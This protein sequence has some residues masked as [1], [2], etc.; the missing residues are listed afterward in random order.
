MNSRYRRGWFGESHRHYLASKGVKTNRYFR[1]LRDSDVVTLWHGTRDKSANKI[2]NEGLEVSRGANPEHRWDEGGYSFL[3]PNVGTAIRHA[4]R[5]PERAE[6]YAGNRP[7][8]LKA[9]IPKSYIWKNNSPSVEKDTISPEEKREY[10]QDIIDEYKDKKWLTR[11]ERIKYL[12]EQYPNFDQYSQEVQEKMIDTVCAD[13]EISAPIH[14]GVDLDSGGRE[15]IEEYEFMV[16]R[17]IPSRMIKKVDWNEAKKKSI[18]QQNKIIGK[19]YGG[20]HVDEQ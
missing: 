20:G 2:L 9:T 10:V 19:N 7:V 3:T 11:G 15:F 18:R 4:D 16:G 12:R 17:K 6:V 5:G 14:K 13:W 8:V 1:K